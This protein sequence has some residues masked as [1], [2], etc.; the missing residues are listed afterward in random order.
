MAAANGEMTIEGS[1]GTLGGPGTFASQAALEVLGRN[2]RFGDDLKY[3]PTTASVW[4]ALWSGQVSRIVLGARTQHTGFVATLTRALATAEGGLYVHAEVVLPYHCH[5]LGRPGTALG[6]VSCVLG[7]G[8]MME[9]TEFL[10]ER[11]PHADRLRHAGSSLAAARDVAAGDGKLAVIG[12]RR[13]ADLL[14]LDILAEDIDRGASASWWAMGTF[15]DFDEDPDHIVVAGRFGPEGGLGTVMTV[16]EDAGWSVR[17]LAETPSGA[18]L[19][20]S[21][22]VIVL[23]GSG[24]L[25][26]VNKLTCS[27]GGVRL[28]GAFRAG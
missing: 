10:D 14:G 7:H 8:S 18:E 25:E 15:P 5:L 12:T 1:V 17:T 6:D 24:G 11:L 13:T 4:E 16:L 22:V 28:A 20:E 21:L 9:C 27:T 26:Q 2:P 23:R 19:F 3:F